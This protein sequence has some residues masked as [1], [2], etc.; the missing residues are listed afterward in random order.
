MCFQPPV[1][2]AFHYF[3]RNYDET[4]TAFGTRMITVE[5][6]A[7]PAKNFYVIQFFFLEP[8]AYLHTS[9]IYITTK[10]SGSKKNNAGIT[11]TFQFNFDRMYWWNFVLMRVP[12]NPRM[13]NNVTAA[14][15][16]AKHIQQ[17]T[18]VA[19]FFRET[20]HNNRRLYSIDDREWLQ[21][22]HSSLHLQK[23]QKSMS[24]VEQLELDWACRM[25]QRRHD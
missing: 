10:T 21:T 22:Q 18:I 20:I 8:L 6:I 12:A 15:H 11:N 9:E 25:R 24:V 17:Q 2:I 7:L 13:S 4:F 16:E 5:L 1:K 14:A 23:L 19:S 3:L